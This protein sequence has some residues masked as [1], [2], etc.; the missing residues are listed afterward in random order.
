M[1]FFVISCLILCGLG[2]SG[3]SINKSI[4]MNR[5]IIDIQLGM[6][7][8]YLI[9]EKGMIMVDAGLPKKI[10]QFQ[11]QLRKLDIEP[12]DIK[13]VVVTHS[14][15]DHVGSLDDIVKLTGAKVAVHELDRPDLEKGVSEI[16]RGNSLWGKISLIMLKPYMKNVRVPGYTR[17]YYQG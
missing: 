4:K 14:H 10:G 6:N 15:F 5:E 17:H 3:Q 2:A 11:K 8:C 16:P 1:K 13:L 7:H 9:K 12:E